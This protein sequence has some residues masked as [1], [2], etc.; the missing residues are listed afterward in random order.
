EIEKARAALFDAR[1]QR[2]R[3]G[4]DDKVLTE[5]NA[6]MISVLAEAGAALERDD[7]IE[8]AIAAADFLLSTL[9][10]DDGRWLRAW[11]PEGGARHLAYAVDYAWLVDAFTRLAEATGQ[12]RWIVDARAAADGLLTLFWDEEGGGF[13]TTGHDAEALIV[14]SKDVFDG[15]TPS[16]NSVAAVAL[17][18]LAA[19]VGESAY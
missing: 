2:V 12:A 10:T 4:L 11:H 17:H 13:F 18:R 9:R 7:W 14:R 19:L 6:M 3:P 15:A 1:S 16:A 8:A 5:W